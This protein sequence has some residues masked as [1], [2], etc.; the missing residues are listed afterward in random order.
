MNTLDMN[1]WVN[2][3]EENA[4][5]GVGFK[6]DYLNDLMGPSKPLGWLEVHAEN[7]M[8]DGGPQMAMLDDIASRY[9]ISCHGVGLSIGGESA[10]DKEHLQRLRVLQDRLQPA[11]FSEHLA[12]STHEGRFFN[13]LLPLPYTQET[14]RRVVEHVDQMQQALGRQI[15]IENPSSYLLFEGSVMGEAEFLT[16]VSEDSGCGL[17]LDV[18]NVFISANNLGFSVGQ[19]IMDFPLHRVGEIHLAGFR[20]DVDEQGEL[21]LIDSH[22]APVA[23]AVWRLYIS[24]IERLGRAVPTLIEWDNDLPSWKVLF[25]DVQSAATNM[26]HALKKVA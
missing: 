6:I 18:N 13:D 3:L 11:F 16:A 20:R 17:L 4:W 7:Y 15:L 9:P 25:A 10:L 12:W 5:L 23:D 14:L 26:S 2:E 19:Y 21:L 22:S 24:V 1:L 8:L